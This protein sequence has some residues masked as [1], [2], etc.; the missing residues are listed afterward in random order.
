MGCADG[1][2]HG[3][4]LCGRRLVCER[5]FAAE[6]NAMSPVTVVVLVLTILMVGYLIFALLYPEKF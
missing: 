4:V 3:G 6:F 2:F 1:C 5:V